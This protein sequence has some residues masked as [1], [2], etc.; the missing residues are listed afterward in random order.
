M[1]DCKILQERQVNIEVT[2]KG[3]DKEIHIKYKYTQI[4]FYDV[5][6]PSTLPGYLPRLII[7]GKMGDSIA[8]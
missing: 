5:I 3:G 7:S 4:F 8:M 6:Q 2:R 1:E